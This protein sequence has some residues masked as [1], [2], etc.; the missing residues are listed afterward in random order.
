MSHSDVLYTERKHELSH[1][2]LQLVNLPRSIYQQS[3]YVIIGIIGKVINESFI[4]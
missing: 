4:N 2:K 1:R 3:S